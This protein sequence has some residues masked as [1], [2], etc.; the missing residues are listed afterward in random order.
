MQEADFGTL[1]AKY[2]KLVY[3][4]CYQFTQNHHTAQDLAQ[5]TYLSVYTHI[6]S[7]PK[8]NPKAWVARIATNKAKDHLKSAYNRRVQSVANDA[9][10][11]QGVMYI[12]APQPQDV[13]QSN[14][15][16]ADITEKIGELK[17]PYGTVAALY[18][19]HQKSVAEIAQSLKRPK[20][21]VQ[22]Q[23]FRARGKLKSQLALA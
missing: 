15:I 17:E 13:V 5:E 1:V 16:C 4:I 19:L 3:T 22:T 23:L 14:T 2:E 18:F 11:S 12:A 20:K 21:T 7:C 6:A 8:D 10:P 9:M